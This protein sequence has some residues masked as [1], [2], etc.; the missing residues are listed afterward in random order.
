MATFEV[1]LDIPEVQITKVEM[2]KNGN[3]MI[4]VESEVEGTHCHKCGKKITKPHGQD[5]KI[6]LRHLSILG[7][8]TYICIYPKRYQCTHCSGNPTSTQNLSW[9]D[10]KS[11]QTKEYEKHVLLQLINSTVI[12]V[13]V[14]ESLGE[15]AVLGIVNRYVDTKVDWKTIKRLDV[16]GIDEISL[17]KGHQDFVTIVTARIGEKVIILAVLKDRKKETVKDF[18]LSIPK[19]LRKTVTVI[20]SDMYDGFINAAKEVFNKRVRIVADRFH[21]AKLYRNCLETLRKIEMK[22]LKKELPEEK[23]KALTGLMW[24]LRKDTKKLTEEE[25][26]TLKLLFGY[27]PLLELA[28]DFRNQ[29]TAIFEEDISK[30]KARRKIKSWMKKVEKNELTCFDKFL[31]TLENRMNEITNYFHD[32]HS[33]GFVE[34]MNNKIKVIKR[35]CYGILNPKSLFQRL[36]LD[37]VGYLE[38][39]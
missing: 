26:V 27:S 7:R 14:K 18:F 39:S 25:K 37:L 11:P 13:S 19:G 15:K 28:Y 5:Q 32:R 34:G 17:K 29:L 12:D 6:T 1:E 23:Y 3:L 20:C 33:S 24:I 16:L 22:R 35:R 36:H 21:V 9:Y 8:K 31:T 38:F 10:L 30:E 4:T 2:D